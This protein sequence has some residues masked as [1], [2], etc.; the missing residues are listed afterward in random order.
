MTI[1]RV[2]SN[3]TLVPWVSVPELECS[4]CG[5]EEH[6]FIIEYRAA[7][8]CEQ[9]TGEHLLI[10]CPVCDYTFAMACKDG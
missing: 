8:R 3:K 9:F 7:D 10:Q 5:Q 2:P 1:T 6:E 4:K